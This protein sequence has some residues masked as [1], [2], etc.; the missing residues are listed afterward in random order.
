MANPIE[1]L[2]QDHEKVRRLFREYNT[3]GERMS[4]KRDA[5]EQVLMEIEIHSKLEEEIF[6]P[7]VRNKGGELEESV[8][9]GYQEHQQ[10]DRL[11]EE[12]RA[13]GPTSDLFE[14]RFQALIGAIEHHVAEEEG[15]MLPEA[16]RVLG[17]ESDQLAQQMIDRREQLMRQL[18]PQLGRWSA[19]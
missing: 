18:S 11:I 7:A 2:K 10:V 15:E 13:M 8:A 1:M 5:A 3:A 6:Y 4:E 9:E 14:E 16:E 17:N 19:L 12:L